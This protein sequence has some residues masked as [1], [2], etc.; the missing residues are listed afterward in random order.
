MV[1]EDTPLQVESVVFVWGIRSVQLDKKS[2]NIYPISSNIYIDI[3]KG[4][5][6]PLL[7]YS[8]KENV[9]PNLNVSHDVLAWEGPAGNRDQK[10]VQVYSDSKMKTSATEALN[11]ENL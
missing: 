7:N 2:S 1:K 11:K 10:P 3:D 8:A 4:D 6:S 9:I 5:I